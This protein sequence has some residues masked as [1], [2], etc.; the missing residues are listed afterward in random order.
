MLTLSSGL[1]HQ[2]T[3]RLTKPAIAMPASAKTPSF[4]ASHRVRLTLWV[5]ASL[6]VPASSSRA[7]RGAPQKTPMRPGTTTT[8]T[9]S[10]L[11]SAM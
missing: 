9:S 2:V 7:T 1:D 4:T 3:I 11:C 8:R 10:P 6:H 5:Q